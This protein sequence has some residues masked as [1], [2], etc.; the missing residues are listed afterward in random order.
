MTGRNV[1]VTGG[2]GLIGSHIVDA[3]LAAADLA[4]FE[5]EVVADRRHGK[6][7][8]FRLGG[9][10]GL[11]QRQAQP[12]LHDKTDDAERGA[13]QRG[14]GMEDQVAVRAAGCAPGVVSGV[15]P[16]PPFVGVFLNCPF[17]FME[18]D[19]GFYCLQGRRQ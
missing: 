8:I 15:V 18:Y 11:G 7:G 19:T 13:A 9:R 10:E 14:E 12:V 17:V 3:A 4:F 2:A 6:S 1:L 16:V 5:Y